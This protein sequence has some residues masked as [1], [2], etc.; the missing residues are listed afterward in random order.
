M[1]S[2]KDFFEW[3]EKTKWKVPEKDVMGM[4]DI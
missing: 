1:K 3:K 4:D 2:R